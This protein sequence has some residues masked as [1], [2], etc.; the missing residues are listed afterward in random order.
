MDRLAELQDRVRQFRSGSSRWQQRLAEGIQ[1]LSGDMDHD[2]RTRL[3]GV[4]RMA[5]TR[6]DADR[7]ADDLVYEVWLHKTAMEAVVEV[8]Q[9]ISDRAAALSDEIAEMFVV[10]DRDVGFHVDV[11]SPIDVLGGI[12]VIPEARPVRDGALKRV[13]T[14]SQG[15]RSGMALATSMLGFVDG[16]IAWVPLLTLPV[17]GYVARRA[18][19]DDRERRKLQRAQDLKRLAAKYVDEITFVVQKDARDAVRRVHREIREHFVARSEQ[20]ERTLQQ[21]MVAAQR[22]NASRAEGAAPP[23]RPDDAEQ[24]VQRLRQEADRLIAAGVAAS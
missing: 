20:L 7:P 22:A 5:E 9:A 16:W 15:Y 18:F 12:H 13:M 21:A 10:F 14:T 11:S 3:R 19:N 23:P 2:L 17:A 1:D 4:S 8:Y 6:A 24:T